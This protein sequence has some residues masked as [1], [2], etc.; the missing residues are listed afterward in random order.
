M[1]DLDAIYVNPTWLVPAIVGGVI[2][3]LG[4]ILGGYCP[5]TS[6]CAG[7][8]PCGG[9]VS[10]S[11]DPPLGAVVMCPD[12]IHGSIA[13]LFAHPDSRIQCL[14]QGCVAE[15]LVQEFHGS[16]FDGSRPL[17]L[18]PQSGDENGW[19]LPSTSFQFP[20]KIE[21]G[22]ARHHDVE[23]QTFGLA[24]APG[25]NELF[26]RRERLGCKAELPQQVGQRLSHRLVVIHY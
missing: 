7:G 1:L 3:G 20:L 22:H 25:V 26:R 11:E 19:N 23:D 5:G 12:L 14:K 21:S 16:L 4:F 9:S 10:I 8:R 2:M 13:D 18:V 17:S 15:R 24:N 6:I